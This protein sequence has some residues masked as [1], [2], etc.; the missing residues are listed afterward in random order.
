VALPGL[1]ATLPSADLTAVHLRLLDIL[2]A[3]VLAGVVVWFRV[4]LAMADPGVLAFFLLVVVVALE[5]VVAPLL[6]WAAEAVVARMATVAAGEMQAVPVGR[7]LA[8]I[9]LGRF[10]FSGAVAVVEATR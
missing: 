1:A 6:L 8:D 3:V 9:L 4:V 10:L 2:L 7:V 5:A